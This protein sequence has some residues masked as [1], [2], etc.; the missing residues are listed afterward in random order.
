[1]RTCGKDVAHEV[2]GVWAPSAQYPEQAQDPDLEERV[3]DAPT[4]YSGAS[5]LTTRF[6]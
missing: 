2:T 5:P 3:C 1:V 4:S 6:F